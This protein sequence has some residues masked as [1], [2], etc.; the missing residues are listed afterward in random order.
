MNETIFES[1]YVS[2]RYGV[3]YIHSIQWAVTAHLVWCNEW[4]IGVLLGWRHSQKKG[5]RTP[6]LRIPYPAILIWD[7]FGIL[8]VYGV[9]I[10]WRLL[11]LMYIHNQ[12]Y[13]VSFGTVY[14]I[15]IGWIQFIIL[16]NRS[17]CLPTQVASGHDNLCHY[18]FWIYDLLTLFIH[19]YACTCTG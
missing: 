9:Y 16:Q 19:S 10:S 1:D 4:I 15:I 11:T 7:L 8:Y 18:D 12:I 6:S 14:S 13:N 2:K 17:Y 5:P 3:P